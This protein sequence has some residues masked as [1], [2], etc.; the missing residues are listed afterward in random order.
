M[1]LAALPATAQLQVQYGTKSLTVSGA[2]PRG[3]VAVLGIIHSNYR[4]LESIQKPES[5]ERADATGLV[6]V[7]VPRPSFRSVWLVV[8]LGTG[9]FVVSSPPGY[10]PRQMAVPQDAI[11]RSG[12]SLPNTR[13]SVDIYIVRRGL[14]A[15]HGRAAEVGVSANPGDAR[16]SVS[17]DQL[18]PVGATS[19]APPV[20]TPGDIVMVFD[21]GFM[22]YWATKLTPSDLS[23]A[24]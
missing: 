11:E 16:M 9:E 12:R 7:T 5:I 2:S 18:K 19:Q 13:P 14:G 8:D 23:G 4:G 6:T 3:D 1:L 10:Q 24:H 17:I 20:L 22:E 15:W 21:A